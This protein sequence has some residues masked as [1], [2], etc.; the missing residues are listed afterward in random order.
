MEFIHLLLLKL[1]YAIYF[2]KHFLSYLLILL[3]LITEIVE[4]LRKESNVIS[5]SDLA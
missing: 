1:G 5:L 2:I 3:L 4:M